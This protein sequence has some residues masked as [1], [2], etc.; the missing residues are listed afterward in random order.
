MLS[1]LLPRSRVK[2]CM[3]PHDLM[4]SDKL[5]LKI[6]FTILCSHICCQSYSLMF[7]AK[8][9]GE[10]LY[11]TFALRFAEKLK[12]EILYATICICVCCKAKILYFDYNYLLS[13]ELPN[14]KVRFRMK[15]Y[16]LMSAAKLKC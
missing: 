15:S 5:K 4:S 1:C 10:I 3:Q 11:A 7:V 16:A 6:Y 9:K 13:C 8:F 2:F 14:L 12:S